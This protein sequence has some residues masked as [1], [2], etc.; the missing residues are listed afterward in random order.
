[1]IADTKIVAYNDLGRVCLKQIDLD[2]LKVM[3]PCIISIDGSTDITGVAILRESDGAVVAS[4]S[5]KHEK[6]KESPVQYKVRLKRTFYTILKNNELI[7]EIFYEEPFIGYA[8]AVKNLFMLRTFVEELKYENEPELDYIVFTE[9]NNQKWKRLFLAPDKCPSGT[10]LQKKHVRDKLVSLLPF[11]S[12]ITQDEVDAI[13]MGFTAVSKLKTGEK[14]DLK[15][16]KKAR[17]FTYNIKFIGADEDDAMIQE[18]YD[19]CKVPK[20]VSEAGIK[21]VT[22]NGRGNWEDL[23]CEHM[24]LEDKLLILK[25]STNKYGNVILK[26]RIGHLAETYKFIYAVIWRKNRKI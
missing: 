21:L 8:N 22:L 26:N 3:E 5:F 12:E 2:A 24:G 18:L 4:L 11:L 20:E 14:D 7:K 13:A 10:E 25:F 17:P 23:V 1:M 15:S 6:Q 19:I 16:K 9:V